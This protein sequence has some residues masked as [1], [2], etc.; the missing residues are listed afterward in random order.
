MSVA[1]QM[2]LGEVKN[3]LSEVVDEVESQQARVT[4][5]KHG[6]PSVVMISV[7]ELSA[8]EETL[9]ILSDPVL[10]AQLRDSRA[11]TA[12]PMTKEQ[13]RAAIGLDG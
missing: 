12:T 10:L 5:T 8:I 6:R 13:V 2:P 4:I 11:E 7:D 9:R 3:R 1:E